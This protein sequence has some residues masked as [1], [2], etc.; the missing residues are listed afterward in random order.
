[1]KCCI[2]ETT[3]DAAPVLRRHLPHNVGV[4]GELARF[5]KDAVELRL[6]GEGLPEWCYVH[7]G[8]LFMRAVVEL[9]EDGQL[10]FVPGTGLPVNQIPDCFKEHAA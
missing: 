8:A 5:D 1:M 6:E 4:A 10:R 9:L 7:N 3:K 2:I